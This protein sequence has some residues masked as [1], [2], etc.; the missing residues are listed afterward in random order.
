MSIL[1][2]LIKN[3]G[4]ISSALGK[5]LARDYLDGQRDILPEAVSLLSCQTKNVRAGAAK[6]IEQIARESPESVS[7]FLEDCFSALEQPERQ[8]RWMIIHTF[9]LCAHLVPE[10]AA[11]AFRFA[12]GYMAQDSGAC[13]WGATI[14]YLGFFG[15]ITAAN[16]QRA[17]PLLAK[18]LMDLPKQARQILYALNN[19]IPAADPT[20][21]TSIENAAQPFLGSNSKST[22]A[23]A[24][25][26]TQ[27]IHK[28]H[29]N[30]LS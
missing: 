11:K 1:P 6:I 16:A 21:L 10:T 20:L 9:G 3:K 4:T 29:Q 12:E 14:K 25:R 30:P 19:L 18:A 22:A 24:R 13:L 15:G 17:F 23:E 8:T 7:P 27:S 28:M 5:Q 2:Q 26:L